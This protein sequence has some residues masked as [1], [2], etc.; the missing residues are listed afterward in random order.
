MKN[1]SEI[2]KNWQ[3]GNIKNG[4]YTTTDENSNNVIVEVTADYVKLTT[5][6]NNGWAKVNYFWANGTTEEIYEK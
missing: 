3:N 4:W 2:L 5:M 6:Q 1:I